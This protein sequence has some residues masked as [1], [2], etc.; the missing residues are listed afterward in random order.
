LS[1]STPK[2]E[3]SPV[4]TPTATDRTAFAASGILIS[5]PWRRLVDLARQLEAMHRE[6]GQ[7][8]SETTTK[9]ANSVLLFQ[10]QLLGQFSGGKH[11]SR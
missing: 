9:L 2:L 1:S 8:D 6:T 3:A 11:P 10:A 4:A 5:V 7:L